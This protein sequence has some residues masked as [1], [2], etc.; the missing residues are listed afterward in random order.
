MRELGNRG[1]EAKCSANLGNAHLLLGQYQQAATCYQ[2]SLD[3]SREIGDRGDEAMSLVNL[4][5]AHKSLGRYQ[6]AIDFYQES[7]KIAREIGERLLEASS[8]RGLGTA[9]REIGEYQ[10]AIKF[11]Q[12]ALKIQREIGDQHGEANSLFELGLVLVR[13]DQR[14]EA[15]QQYGQALALYEGLK[16]NHRVEECKTAIAQINQV[17]TTQPRSAPSI[18]AERRNDDDW[19]AKS[20]P[21]K[22]KPSA[23]PSSRQMQNWWLWFGVGLAIAL[24]IWW[25]R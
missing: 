16:L 9:F 2:Q 1:G 12:K 20:L 18:G 15:L 14:F 24:I 7:L 17:P 3:I 23:S 21:T 11:L 19:Y 6:Q 25:L 8:F 4:G 22:R 10:Q 13:M 5:N